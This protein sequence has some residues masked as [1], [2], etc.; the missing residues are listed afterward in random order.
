MSRPRPKFCVGEEVFC[1]HHDLFGKTEVLSAWW[2]EG[3]VA[4]DGFDGAEWVYKLPID[5]IPF[6]ERWLR[7][8]PPEERTQWKDCAWQPTNNE[9]TA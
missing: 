5:S 6:G 4:F 8:L 9:V 2:D 1:T 3:L 7:K